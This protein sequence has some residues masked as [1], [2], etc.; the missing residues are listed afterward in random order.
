[1]KISKRAK[2]RDWFAPKSVERKDLFA[3]WVDSIIVELNNA[4]EQIRHGG[5]G[6]ELVEDL[7]QLFEG[8]Q[9]AIRFYYQSPDFIQNKEAKKLLIKLVKMANELDKKGFTRE[10]DKIDGI[11]KRAKHPKDI[12]VSGLGIDFG[13][14]DPKKKYFGKR[15]LNETNYI[16]EIISN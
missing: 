8:A 16:N 14:M 15:K 1:M 4:S 13:S 12:D 10:A 2:I 3:D 5:A 11:I 9:D 7:Q 6:E